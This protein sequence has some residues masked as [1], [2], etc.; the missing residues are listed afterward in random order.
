MRRQAQVYG[1]YI[2]AAH[3]PTGESY[4]VHV[5]SNRGGGHVYLSGA[6]FGAEMLAVNQQDGTLKWHKAIN[7]GEH[8]SPAV[9]SSSV[10]VS[11]A[12]AATS[13]FAPL[14]GELQWQFRAAGGGGGRTPFFSIIDCMYATWCFEDL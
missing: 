4:P 6:G 11:Y 10:Y 7:G 5:P 13:A 8:S 1:R 14:T 9:S 2:L 3:I 12:G